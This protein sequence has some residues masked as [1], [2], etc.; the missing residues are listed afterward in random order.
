MSCSC[1]RVS[2]LVY[3]DTIVAIEIYSKYS[4]QIHSS[5][6][7]ADLWPSDKSEKTSVGSDFITSHT[8]FFS[9]WF[10]DA[11]CEVAPISN[12]HSLKN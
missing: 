5:F 4:S 10:L 3:A 8:S 1:D 9:F 7:L 12:G 11:V 6:S 2:G